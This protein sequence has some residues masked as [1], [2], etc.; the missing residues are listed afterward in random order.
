M[1]RIF[2][3][4]R[5]KVA[6]LLLLLSNLLVCL[7]LWMEHTYDRVRLDQILFLLKSSSTGVHGALSASAAFY[8]GVISVWVTALQAVL[9]FFLSG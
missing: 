7:M 4:K 2:F 5:E 9:Y 6:A 1:T 8:V 3:S